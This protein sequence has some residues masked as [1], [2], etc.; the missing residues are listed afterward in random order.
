MEIVDDSCGV[1]VPPG[2]VE[3]LARTL[4]D[5]VIDRPRRESLAAAAPARARRLCDPATQLAALHALLRAM[6]QKGHAA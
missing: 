4:R 1:L 5:L 2:D 6:Q 3:A